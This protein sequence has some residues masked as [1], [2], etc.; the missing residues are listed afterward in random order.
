MQWAEDRIPAAAL[1][2][3]CTFGILKVTKT[4][5]GPRIFL[6]NPL[7]GRPGTSVYIKR[8]TRA[9]GLRRERGVRPLPR[10]AY[11]IL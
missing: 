11:G 7:S 3:L 1:I 4:G 8:R 5:R 10:A 6:R 2:L 9:K